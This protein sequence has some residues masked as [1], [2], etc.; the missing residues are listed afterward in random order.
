V[1]LKSIN[2][3]VSD[4]YSLFNKDIVAS[5][6]QVEELGRALTD[7]LKRRLSVKPEP[8]GLSMSGVGT[9]CKRKLWYSVNA[10]DKAEPLDPQ[11]KLNFLYGDI[12]D[13]LIPFL[14]KWAGRDVKGE[15][16]E[17]EIS[18]VKGHRDLVLDGVTVDVKTANSRSIDKFKNHQLEKEDP[19]GYIEQLGCYVAAG[20]DDPDVIG[21]REGAF[22]VFDKERGGLVVDRY[23]FD[24]QRLDG[25]RRD[26]EKS[27]ELVSSAEPPPRRY[28]PVADGSYGNEVI[29]F[30]C[31]YC[32][33]KEHCWSD[34]NEGRGLIKYIFSNGPRWFTKIVREPKPRVEQS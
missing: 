14:C 30:Q 13:T 18:G 8:R 26:V 11:T 6:A 9:K 12:I 24:E 17:L 5:E 7:M 22:V 4:I 25:F 2:T 1:T 20:A 15:Q 29:P 10:Q 16:T 21:K 28:A 33:Y 19:F 27:K 34:A 3:L 32:Q 31:A 23:L